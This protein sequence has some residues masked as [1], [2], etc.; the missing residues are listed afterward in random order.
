MRNVGRIENVIERHKE[1]SSKVKKGKPNKQVAKKRK[2]GNLF[3]K[4]EYWKG[5]KTKKGQ[6]YRANYKMKFFQRK[7]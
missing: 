6:P 7:K 2:R 1:R 5:V 3:N 4:R